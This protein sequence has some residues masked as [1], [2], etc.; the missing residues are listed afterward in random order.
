GITRADTPA[1]AERYRVEPYVVA[2]DV[3]DGHA[4]YRGRGGW[5]WYTGSA[6]WMYR[7]MVESLL[8]LRLEVDRLRLAPCLPEGWEG[9]TLH[10]RFGETVYH[11]TVRQAPAGQGAVRVS[12]DGVEQDDRSIP[13]V[14]DRKDHWAEVSVACGSRVESPSGARF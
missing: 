12:L 9:F 14:D 10:Y 7:L 4:D 8:G 3:Y 5:T 13:L 6:A 1:D 2:A 11:I